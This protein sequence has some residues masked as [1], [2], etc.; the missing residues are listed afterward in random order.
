MEVADEFFLLARGGG[1]RFRV[2]PRA[3]GLA[4]AGA[5][6]GE[7]VFAGKVMVDGEALWVVDR[8][9]PLDGLAHS[10]LD[11]L[12]AESGHSV[13]SWLEY[14]GGDAADRVTE[15]LVRAGHLRRVE[16]RRWGRTETRFV[17]TDEARAA[18]PQVRLWSAVDRGVPFEGADGFLA[19]L[20]QASGLGWVVFRDLE[21][22]ARPRDRVGEAVAGL[23][24]PQRD[25]VEQVRAAVSDTV[26]TQRG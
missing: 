13:R 25:L 11:R 10:T 23:P 21:W 20:I 16:S 24:P 8:W 26:L 19:G 7:L 15:R 1:G 9:P 6:V 18:L 12:G 2:R 5:L 14:L 22:G 4:L 3:L 17:A